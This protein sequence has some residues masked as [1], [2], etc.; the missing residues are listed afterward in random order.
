[1]P[2]RIGQSREPLSHPYNYELLRRPIL[3]SH[4]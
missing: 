3:F 1:M 4:G 2:G